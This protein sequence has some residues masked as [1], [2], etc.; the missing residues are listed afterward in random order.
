MLVVQDVI[1]IGSKGG[2]VP[3]D[4]PT[5]RV[6]LNDNWSVE[7]WAFDSQCGSI[8]QS[9]DP[10][11]SGRTGGNYGITSSP[12]VSN[13]VVYVPSADHLLYAFKAKGCGFSQCEQLWVGQM[14]AGAIDSS[15]VVDGG[16][17]FIGTFDDRLFVFPAAGCGRHRCAG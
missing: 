6:L 10:I 5:V 16:H 12:V 2:G 1:G 17:V 11:W 7:L 13:G 3:A 4:I 9:C 8:G 14:S 15:P